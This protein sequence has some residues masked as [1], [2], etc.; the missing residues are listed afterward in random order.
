MCLI[1]WIIWGHHSGIM[2]LSHGFHEMW[3][4]DQKVNDLHSMLTLA[5]PKTTTILEHT[6]HIFYYTHCLAKVNT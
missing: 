3:C 1:T 4:V 2:E 6:G 5:R